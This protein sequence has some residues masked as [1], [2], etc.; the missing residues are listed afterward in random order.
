MAD[1]VDKCY[2]HDY[3]FFQ[4]LI[5]FIIF[6]DTLPPLEDIPEVLERVEKTR[7]MKEAFKDTEK[8]SKHEVTEKKVNTT[9]DLQ[10]S[11]PKSSSNFCGMKKGFLFGGS[12]KSSG[13][14]KREAVEEVPMIKARPENSSL[15]LKQVQEAMNA[16]NAMEFQ[17]KLAQRLEANPSVRDVISDPAWI[18]ILDEFQQNPEAAMKKYKDNR[19]ITSTLKALCNVLGDTFLHMNSSIRSEE[20]LISSR[21]ME[22]PHVK[23]ALTDPFVQEMMVFMKQGANDKVHRHCMAPRGLNTFSLYFSFDMLAISH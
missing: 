18:P 5:H 14:N 17:A 7:Q 20:E 6:I 21:L 13:T 12:T 22:S 10:K 1:G 3:F 11:V 8:V 9:K 19:E 4:E 16:N 23:E 15:V 2:L